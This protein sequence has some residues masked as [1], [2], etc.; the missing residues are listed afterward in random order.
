[1]LPECV[2]LL[3]ELGRNMWESVSFLFLHLPGAGVGNLN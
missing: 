3:E 1:M 2:D